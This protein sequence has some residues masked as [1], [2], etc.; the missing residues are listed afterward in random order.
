MT[1]ITSPSNPHIKELALLRQ[2]RHRNEQRRFLVEGAREVSRASAAGIELAEILCCPALGGSVI[3]PGPVTEVS[4]AAFRKVSSRRHP[5]G[6]LA[7]A[8]CFDV[9]EQRLE[10][11][12]L[13]IVAEQMEKPGNIGAMLRTADAAG[14]GM[15]LADAVADVFNP[16]VV[17]A[18]QGSLFSVPIAVADAR[19]ARR[20]LE[21]HMQILVASPGA[22][23]PLWDVDL[24]RPTAVVVGAEH[25][26]VSAHWA[27]ADAISIPMTGSA[28]S[29]NA[30]VA[31]AVV[32]FEAVRQRTS[33][34]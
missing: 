23:R 14:A 26:G 19:A 11:T 16:N 8:C 17:R 22:Q 9:S 1:V 18:S 33:R 7:V 13:V 30:S 10:G 4:E 5:D 15:F 24:T 3:V 2:R 28:D 25:A 27:G 32:L 34:R 21:G 31:A 29:L 20:W 6:I 12:D